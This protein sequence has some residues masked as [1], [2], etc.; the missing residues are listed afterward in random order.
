MRAKC[1]GQLLKTVKT[2]SGKT[3]FSPLKI[4]CYKSLID[5]IKDL[6]QNPG[7]I[8]L[9]NKWKNHTIPDGVMCDIHDV[10]VWKS[11]QERKNYFRI[12]ILWVC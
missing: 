1:Q 5:S 8:D 3:I 10:V 4:Y 12:D 9:L 6:I 7:M 11:F 2:A